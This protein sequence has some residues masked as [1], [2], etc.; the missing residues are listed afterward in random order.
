LQHFH[1]SKR[2]TA[3]F[4]SLALLKLSLTAVL[5]ICLAACHDSSSGERVSRQDLRLA[6]N[7]LA[8]AYGTELALSPQTVS[9]SGLDTG[10][11]SA[12][13]YNL[14]DHSQAGFERRRLTRIELLQRLENRPRLPA[15]LALETDLSIAAK[16][17]ARVVALEQTGHGRY[18]TRAAYPYTID[19][20]SGIWIDGIGL[21]RSSHQI[22][23]MADAEA[24]LVRLKLLADAI[25]D[26]RRR[27]IADDAVGYALPKPL[28]EATIENI[29]LLINDEAAELQT[30]VTTLSNLTLGLPDISPPDRRELIK[31]AE[32]ILNTQIL[33]AYET[34]S[35][36]LK[37]LV[38]TAPLQAGLWN[39]PNGYATLQKLIRFHLTSD[40]SLEQ[41]HAQNVE[42]VAESRGALEAMLA[43]P[44]DMETP[45]SFEQLLAANYAPPEA[46][47]SPEPTTNTAPSAPLQY[48][49]KLA[50]ITDLEQILTGSNT[51]PTPLRTYIARRHSD[52]DSAGERTAKQ[53]LFPHTAI[54]SAIQRLKAETS[55]E[56]LE[57]AHFTL[58]ETLA[59]T[60]DSGLNHAKWSF[61]Q[62]SGYI[63]EHSG[64]SQTV[65]DE[66]VNWVAA[67][68]GYEIAKLSAYRRLIAL[69]ERAR[70]VLGPRYRHSEFLNVVAETGPRPLIMI[71]ADIE[72]WYAAK[73]SP[74][75]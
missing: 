14:D 55:P 47:A 16:T 63:T 60:A 39:Q 9:L 24:Y 25:D 18:S 64:L 72:R 51:V 11:S 35:D 30:L 56:T 6:Q 23:S 41:A 17:L 27:I 20:F 38:E 65:A 50:P 44:E 73:L 29:D 75:N 46:T 15:S 52:A 54:A 45:L 57:Y 5:L 74:A 61:E 36:T 19:P 7:I 10:A 48:T 34:L 69:S 62:T 22:E 59:A 49:P 12:A 71:E 70:A 3:T 68:P 1:I 40:V 42:A 43:S 32:A 8:D 28:L 4:N 26:A 2:L 67:N 37:A 13:L 21:L 33:P 66:I 31:D 53:A 58:I